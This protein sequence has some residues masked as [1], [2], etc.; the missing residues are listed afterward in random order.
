[1]QSPSENDNDG[2]GVQAQRGLHHLARVHAGLR[3][4]APEQLDVLDDA[5]LCVQEDGREH[6]MLQAPKAQ[7]EEGA[8]VSRRGNQAVAHHLFV[9]DGQ[10]GLDDLAGAWPVETGRCRQW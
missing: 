2:G 9:K 8:G 5:V 7:R 1:M 4:R 3:Q 10:G 6:F